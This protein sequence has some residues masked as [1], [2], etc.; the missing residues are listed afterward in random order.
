LNGVSDKYDAIQMDPLIMSAARA[1]AA[2]DPIAALNLV[3]LRDD[4]PALALRGIATSFERKLFCEVP[5]APSARKRLSLELARCCLQRS[6]TVG[7]RNERLC[8][9]FVHCL[10]HVLLGRGQ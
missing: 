2:G 6:E 1:P 4:A 8:V 9:F 10:C 7:E 3:A 5:R